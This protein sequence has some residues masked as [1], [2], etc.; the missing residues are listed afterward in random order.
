MSASLEKD[1]YLLL[2]AV[3]WIEDT[4][5]YL[6][7]CPKNPGHVKDRPRPGI[8]HNAMEDVM[9]AP[10][11]KEYAMAL[12]PMASA[13]F[14]EPAVLWSLNAFYT[15]PDT[16]YVPSVNGVHRDSEAPKILTLF[17][18]GYDTD[19]DGAQILLSPDGSSFRAFYGPAGT[20]WLADTSR[21]H[22]GLLPK[23]ERLLLWARWA[24]ETPRA[25]AG[26]PRIE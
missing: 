24:N 17:I 18:L 22:A 8:C 5:D 15:S 11:F 26:L 14:G 10:Y 4:V 6:K 13:F 16:P 2:P 19:V 7:M 12:T 25:A 21:I 1:G 3:T 20:A 9:T 23:K